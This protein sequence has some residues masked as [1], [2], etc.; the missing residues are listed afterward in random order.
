MGWT[1]GE[2][3]D[4][5]EMRF[6]QQLLGESEAAAGAA[7]GPVAGE[8]KELLLEVSEGTKRPCVQGM[9]LPDTSSDPPFCHFHSIPVPQAGTGICLRCSAPVP[10]L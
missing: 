2:Q 6:S 1:T 9:V 10:H 4:S 5:V 7:L 3:L 8:S